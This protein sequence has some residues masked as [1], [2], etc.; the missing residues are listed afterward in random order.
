MNDANNS[1]FGDDQVPLAAL[2]RQAFNLRW[3][4]LPEDVIPLT[5]ADPDF[6][7][8]PAVREA[9]A[10]QAAEGLFS[11]GPAAGLPAF[12]Q[13]C[14]H[15]CSDRRGMGGGP[16][17]ILAVDGAAAGMLHVC[18]LLLRP[19]DEA[20]IFDPVDFLF[21]A[22]VEAAGATVVRLPV[23]P[24]RGELALERLEELV[25]PRTRL[26]GVC[27]PL[28]PVGRVLRRQELEALASFAARHDLAIL[29]DEVWSDIVFAAEPDGEATSETTSEAPR[30]ATG[31]GAG[32]GTGAGR[33]AQRPAATMAGTALPPTAAPAG[34]A[35]RFLSL[36]ALAPE[37]AARCWTVHGFSK[38]YGLAGL[39]VGYVHCPDAGSCERLLNASL[40]ET[41]MHGVATLS[42]IAAVAA[43]EQ[44]EAWLAAWL[45]HLERQRN[46]AVAELATMPGTSVRSPEGTYV[47][48]PRVNHHGLSAEALTERLLQRQRLAVVPGAARWFGP[49]ATGHLRLVFS[50]SEAILR[51]GLARLRRGLEELE[52]GSLSAPTLTPMR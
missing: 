34:P 25:T 14:A 29:N 44:G 52:E 10:R 15:F 4:T 40:A 13:A 50:T 28:N 31:R 42:Q 37:V 30:A 2:R 24:D 45:V 3:A 19:G 16:E 18:R 9:I 23:D 36:A 8:A 11:Y 46:L 38:N 32:D 7:V 35:V 39:R 26:L 43:L 20:I 51:E 41:T 49:G 48:F 21:Q 1:W 22:A 33:A 17:R 12:R 5:A 27:N 47:L 6:A